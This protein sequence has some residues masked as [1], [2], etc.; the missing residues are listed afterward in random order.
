MASNTSIE[1]GSN[2]DTN[3]VASSPTNLSSPGLDSEALRAIAANREAGIS[4]DE[5]IREVQRKLLV[6]GVKVREWEGR[7]GGAHKWDAS[8]QAAVRGDEEFRDEV[9]AHSLL[10]GLM[11]E[12]ARR[13]YYLR[14]FQG[15]LAHNS[16]L[17]AA[18]TVLSGRLQAGLDSLY[19]C[20][21]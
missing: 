21:T 12:D 10:G 14:G 17:F 1:A 6:F 8:L 7:F 4:E 16:S 3:N 2:G 15:S 5:L 19:Y 13:I 18:V 9:L 11:L 20:L